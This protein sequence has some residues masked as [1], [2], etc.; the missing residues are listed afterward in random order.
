MLC[1][2]LGGGK[3]A[4]FGNQAEVDAMDT[5]SISECP[6][7]TTI[8][9]IGGKWKPMILF[10][11]K[12]GPQRFS[13]LRRLIEGTTQKVL[14]EQLRELEQDQIVERK[15]YGKTP[16][17]RVEYSLSEY[18]ETLRPML[19]LMCDWGLAHRARDRRRDAAAV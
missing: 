17:L 4:L 9:V 16:P 5:M 18:G 11:L 13:E 10:W 3:K 15:V 19:N 12:T 2:I 7:K 1:A 6:V 14:T 8:D